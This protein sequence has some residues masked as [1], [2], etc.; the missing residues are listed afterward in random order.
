MKRINNI[1]HNIYKLENIMYCFNEIC[2]NTRNKDKVNTYK[3]FKV[4]NIYNIYN[5]LKNKT[6]KVGKFN[7]FYIYEPKKEE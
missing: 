3:E 2:K 7:I 4:I 1:Y 5:K 6:Y